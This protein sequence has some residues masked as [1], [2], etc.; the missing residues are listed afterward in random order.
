[1][2]PTTF[3]CFVISSCLLPL[4][5]LSAND[6]AVEARKEAGKQTYMAV[7]FACHQPT[8]MGLPGM[9]PPVAGTD[10]VN[11]QKPDRLIRMV[12]HGLVG[13]IKINGVPFA[14]PAPIMPPQGML[15]DDQIA[16]VL[17]YLRSAFG[18]H[19]AA[20]TPEEVAAI[21]AAEGART[22]PWTEAELLK[23]PVE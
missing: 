5:S 14:T 18:N 7:C 21:R 15:P 10:W 22:T 1:M 11:A 12:L 19:A 13:P 23:I 16:N 2:N 17:T 20:V 6:P 4:S 8:G 3:L 9:F